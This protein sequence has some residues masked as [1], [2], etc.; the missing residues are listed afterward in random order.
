M[1]ERNSKSKKNLKL[2]SAIILKVVLLIF[3]L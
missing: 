1:D 2:Y 3:L